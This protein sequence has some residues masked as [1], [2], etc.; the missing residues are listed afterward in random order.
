MLSKDKK[1]NILSV[2]SAILAAYFLQNYSD[3]KRHL[4]L[5]SGAL[6]NTQYAN[7][8][9]L[10]F[11]RVPKAGSETLWGL[12]DILSKQNGFISYSDSAEVK[13]QRGAENTFLNHEQRKSYVEMLR[14]DDGETNITHNSPYCYIKHINFL[15]FEEFNYTNPIYVNMVR[16]PIER[17]ISWYYYTRQGWYQLKWNSAKNE[18]ELKSKLNPTM[19][20]RTY[21]ECVM[22]QEDECIYPVGGKIHMGRYG[23]SHYSQVSFEVYFLNYFCSSVNFPDFLLLRNGTGMWWIW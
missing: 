7:Q 20:K 4:V 10:I 13:Q 21:E 9:F 1:W 18:T 11:N 19:M 3:L 14:D 8:S 12:L 16:H 6:N 5:E 22:E 15:N 2:L 23:G 17:L